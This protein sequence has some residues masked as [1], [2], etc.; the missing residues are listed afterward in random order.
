MLAPL[1]QDQLIRPSD[2]VAFAAALTHW[3][4]DGLL[5]AVAAK[6]Q[7]AYVRQFNIEV[8]GRQLEEAYSEALRGR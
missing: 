1:S 2:T 6:A 8:V 7:K 4:D 3:L 5:R